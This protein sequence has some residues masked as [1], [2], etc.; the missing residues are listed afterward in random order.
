V[1]YEFAVAGTNE[2]IEQEFA[3]VAK[4]AREGRSSSS[5]HVSDAGANPDAAVQ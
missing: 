4:R 3:G 1:A 5:S 2:R